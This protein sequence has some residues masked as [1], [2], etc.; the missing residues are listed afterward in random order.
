[1]HALLSLQLKSENKTKNK[2]YSKKKISGGNWKVY[3]ALER[4]HVEQNR[5]PSACVSAK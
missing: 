3:V 5:R 4:E 1:M 2:R